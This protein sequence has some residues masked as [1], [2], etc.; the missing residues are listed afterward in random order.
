MSPTSRSSTNANSHIR[1]TIVGA[2]VPRQRDHDDHDIRPE[3]LI[4]RRIAGDQ[5]P[6]KWELPGGG[7]DLGVDKTLMDVAVRELREETRLRAKEVVR[8]VRTGRL[9]HHNERVL[10]EIEHEEPF[11]SCSILSIIKDEESNDCGVVTFIVEVGDTSRP[12]L[13][14]PSEHVECA[15]AT[16]QDARDKALL[17]L[18]GKGGRVFDFVSEAMMRHHS[19]GSRDIGI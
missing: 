13:I 14:D 5:F 17:G 2:M 7:A 1:S 15:W 11:N 3:K 19:R 9:G 4:L 8:P 10:G 16:E 18:D 12:I 6:L